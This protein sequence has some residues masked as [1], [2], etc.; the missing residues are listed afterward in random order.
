MNAINPYIIKCTYI[1]A[2]NCPPPN[3]TYEERIVKWHELEIILW[4]EGYIITEGIKIPVKKGDLLFRN[5]GITVQGISPYHCYLVVFD[6]VY[7]KN[8]ESLYL[9]TNWFNQ[10]SGSKTSIPFDLPYCISVQ[11]L[12]RYELLFRLIYSQY[13]TS[14]QTNQFYLKTY[15]M[16]LLMLADSEWSHSKMLQ[17]PSRSIRA[18][19]AKVMEIKNYIDSHTTDRIKLDDL[20][21]YVDLSRNFLCKIFKEIL[22][23]SIIEYV[24]LCKIN[25]VKKELLDTHKSIKEICI[26]FGFENEPYFYSLFKKLEGIRPSE[27]R[28]NNKH[29]FQYKSKSNI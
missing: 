13:I 14:G 4:G 9:D 26:D 28:E 6:I 27:Y 22:G 8:R 2:D 19:Y 18:N 10:Q 24:N 15:L 11:Q 20:A 16:Q 17:H 5:P 12:T 7:N 23:C 29:L 25:R 21:V 3:V 1:N